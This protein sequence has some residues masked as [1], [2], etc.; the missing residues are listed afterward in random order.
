VQNWAWAFLFSIIADFIVVDGI[1]MG[2]VTIITINVGSAP[3]A[4][5]YKRD[6]CLKLIPPAVKDS[7]E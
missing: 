5:G 3:D 1:F 4:C 2:V 6:F 7:I